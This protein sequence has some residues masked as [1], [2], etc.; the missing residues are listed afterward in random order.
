MDG[1][2]HALA[3]LAEQVLLVQ[4]HVG[5]L[6]AGVRG[7]AGAHVGHRDLVAGGVDGHEE[8]G[9]ALVAGL[10]S[11]VTAMTQANSQ[12]SVWGDQPLPRR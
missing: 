11:S 4:L 9:Q 10:D 8:G 3:F 5:E 7:A 2:L 1:D 12:Q 6:Q